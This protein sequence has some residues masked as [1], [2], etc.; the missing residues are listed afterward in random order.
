MTSVVSAAAVDEHSLPVTERENA[1]TKSLD[2]SS[3]LEAIRLLRQADAQIF[4]G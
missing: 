1:L 2:V 4:T 3:P